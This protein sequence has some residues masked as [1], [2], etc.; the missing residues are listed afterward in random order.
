[1][2]DKDI[3]N[4]QLLELY[5]ASKVEINPDY[6]SFKK[7]Y[8][9][10]I[11]KYKTLKEKFE[12][13]SIELKNMYFEKLK[14]DEHYFKT[15]LP[16]ERVISF[17][18]IFEIIDSTINFL[19]EQYTIYNEL[20]KIDKDSYFNNISTTKIVWNGQ[21]NVLIDIFYQYKREYTKDKK[22]IISNSNEEIAHFL[23]N[24]FSCFENTKI[25]TIKTQLNKSDRPKKAENRLKIKK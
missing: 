20:L 3:I 4:K 21:K 14:V 25:D 24:T 19:K 12:Y 15:T 8:Y 10:Q 18:I 9:N 2:K 22:P 5:K 13:I 6:N 11:K 17:N 23:K 1:M 16:E 7:K